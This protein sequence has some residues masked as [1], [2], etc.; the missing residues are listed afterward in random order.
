MYFAT[1][2]VLAWAALALSVDGKLTYGAIALGDLEK[3]RQRH[4]FRGKFW[5]ELS[6]RQWCISSDSGHDFASPGQTP[7]RHNG[8]GSADAGWPRV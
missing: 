4:E 1:S 7:P 2:G 6:V 3:T 8:S 5:N